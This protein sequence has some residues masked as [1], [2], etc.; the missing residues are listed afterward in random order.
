LKTKKNPGN[1]CGVFAREEYEF[2]EKKI[3][4]NKCENAGTNCLKKVV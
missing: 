1:V 3:D 2:K 4:F